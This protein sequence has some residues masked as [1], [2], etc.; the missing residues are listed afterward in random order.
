MKAKLWTNGKFCVCVPPQNIVLWKD[1]DPSL[2]LSPPSLVTFGF[3][4]Y[5]SSDSSPAWS[6][7]T[8]RSSLALFFFSFFKLLSRVPPCPPGCDFPS[9]H[10]FLPGGNIS[11]LHW[12]CFK[13]LIQS[14]HLVLLYR[15]WEGPDSFAGENGN[16][17]SLPE[18]CW[19]SRNSLWNE[20]RVPW[21]IKGRYK[22]VLLSHI[23]G[24]EAQKQDSSAPGSYQYK[25]NQE[26]ERPQRAWFP[27]WRMTRPV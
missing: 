20:Q 23:P 6:H 11:C 16:L 18:Q 21:A 2:S 7:C 13:Q 17:D 12:M 1:S 26:G 8:L 22:I 15:A 27:E 19:V 5:F 14:C 3:C 9:Y 25:R 4:H 24:L 10:P